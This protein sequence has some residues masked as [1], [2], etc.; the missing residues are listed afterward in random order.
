ML[1]LPAAGL[2][3]VFYRIL[4]SDQSSTLVVIRRY[5]WY[6]YPL[7]RYGACFTHFPVPGGGGKTACT[8]I[9]V[10]IRTLKADFSIRSRIYKF[11]RPR[12]ETAFAGKI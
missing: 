10:K 6:G 9:L 3:S 5:I 12:A 8:G 2:Q 7:Y 1:V 11:A 4:I